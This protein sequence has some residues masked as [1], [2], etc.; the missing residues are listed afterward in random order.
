MLFNSRPKS[1]KE[2]DDITNAYRMDETTCINELLSAAK[3][4]QEERL[5][6][7]AKAKELVKQARTYKKAENKLSALLH[8]YDLSTNEGIALM[9][10]AEALLRIPDTRTIDQ[11]ISDKLAAGQWL[12]HYSKDQ[13]FFINAA[14]WSLLLTGKIFGPQLEP[15]KTLGG[16]LKRSIS[17]LGIPLIRPII[18]KM[19]QTIGNQFVLGETIESALDQSKRIQENKPYLFSYDM[20]GEAARTEKEANDYYDAYLHAIL[21]AG[22]LAASDDILKN[23]GI[24]IKLSALFPRYEASQREH[25]LAVIPPKLLSLV[26]YAQS[27]RMTLIVDAEEADRLDLSLDIFEKVFKDPSLAN[28][29]GFGMALQAYQ[30]RAYFVLDWLSALAKEENK[31]IIVRLVKGAYWDTEIKASQVLGLEDYPVFTRKNST[32]VS[33]LACAKK[34]LNEPAQ[35]YPQFGSHNAFSIAAVLKLGENKSFELQGLH[36]MN[37]P[38]YDPILEDLGFSVPCRIYAPVGTHRHL[39]GYLV[40]RLLENGANAS[41]LN[42]LEDERMTL[43]QLVFDPILR[44]GALIHKSHPKIPLP[45]DIYHYWRNSKGM[46]L[47]D[48]KALIQLK[49]EM[50]RADHPKHKAGAILNGKMRQTKPLKKVYAPAHADRIIGEVA[51]S[52]QDDIKEAVEQAKLAQK[53]W[54]D[55]SFLKRAVLLEKT[56][57]KLEHAMPLLMTLITRE[58]GRCIPD[59]LSEVREAADFCRYYAHRARADLASHP[60]P[61]PTGEQNTLS[62]HPRGIIVCISPWNFPLAIF[63][64]QIAAALVT[65]N[66]VIA[67]PAE[68]TP[69]IAAKAIEI[70]HEAGIPK[71]ALQL[72]IGS[73][74]EVGASLVAHQDIAGVLFTGSFETAQIINQTLAN[75]PGPI[76]AFIAETGGQNAMIADSSI[77]PEQTVIDVVHS[78]FN[79]AGQRCSA[80]R[81]LFVQENIA[82]SLLDMLAGY[83]QT[84]TIG[85][86]SLLSTDIGPLIDQ[87][88]LNTLENHRSLMQQH[89][90]QLAEVPSRINQPGY[91]FAPCAFEIPDLHLLKKEVFGPILHVIRYQ[92][93]KLDRVMDAIRNTGYGLTFGIQS[94]IETLAQ[95]IASQMP[96]G[97]SYINRNIIGAAVG[98][99]PFGGERL[100]GTGPK[101]GGP[102]Y[103][104]RLCVERTISNNTTAVGG[105]ARLVSTLEED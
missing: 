71:Q 38:I 42:Q 104:P 97:N 92:A 62:L 30:K 70:F 73:G 80:L 7:E 45:K 69:L 37:R 15:Q 51:A 12:D 16:A 53:S 56:A 22:K 64:G 31:Q 99:Q 78:A 17:R 72:L 5:Q 33:Y 50:E 24:S 66:T 13:P 47:T 48:S 103:L 1:T 96:I 9:C 18:F 40:R 26:Q 4:E 91:Y 36:G 49:R 44:V 23:P 27:N 21:E 86:P 39:L 74:E 3:L 65:G 14:T 25:V 77:L 28:W 85:E 8:Q 41:F 81:V 57:E 2:R 58:G 55:T 60:L 46:D 93:N 87:D 95:S 19:M 88:A 43:D 34:L 82:S 63:V 35:F 94:R 11:F 102:Y 98:V 100:S 20:L 67:K 79:S 52:S 54:G 83:M 89:A 68:Q 105:N 101:A 32:D 10:L 6:I 75:R 61:G 84:L 29:S 90:K 76:A 59:C